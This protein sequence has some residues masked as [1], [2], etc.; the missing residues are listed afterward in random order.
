MKGVNSTYCCKDRGIGYYTTN[1][2]NWYS[3]AYD[4]A[5]MPRIEY[6]TIAKCNRSLT[7]NS[8]SIAVEVIVEVLVSR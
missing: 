4:S 8:S 5:T 2:W 1:G 7:G 3:C 6:R